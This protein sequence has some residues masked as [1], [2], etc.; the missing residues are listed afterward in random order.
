MDVVEA[1]KREIDPVEY[2]GRV[3]PLQKS[4]RSFKG[5]CPF[6]TE[7]T[8]SFYVFPDRGTWRCFGSCGEGGDIF[9]F[10]QKRE[11]SDFRGA[12]RTLAAEAGIELSAEDSRKR[13]HNERLAATM[14]A[15]V[16]Y[17][18]RCL[19][20]PGGEAAMAY[21]TEKRGLEQRTIETWRLGWAPDGWRGL[22]DFLRNRG[23]EDRDMIGAGLLIEGE[24]GRE[25]YDRFRGRVIIPIANERGE[26]IAM[27]G[28]GLQGE[29]PKYLNSPQTDLFDKGRTLFGLNIAA[30][31]I[32]E[33]STAIVVEGYMDVLGPWQAG[34]TNVVATMGTSLTENHAAL[35]KRFAKRIV[36]AMDPD[37]AGLAAAERAGDLFLGMQSA[38]GMGQSARTADAIT[39]A[40]QIDLRVAPLPQ[41]KDPDEVARETPDI[42]RAAIEDAPTFPEFLLR[43]LMDSETIES[44][45]QARATVDRL[46]PVLLAVSDP[47]ERAMYVQRVARHLGISEEA[48][49]ERLRAGLPARPGTPGRR[50]EQQVALLPEDVLLALLLKHPGLRQYFKNYPLTL[51]TGALER[52]LFSRWLGNGAFF[53]ED[54]DEDPVL[55][56]ARALEQK[57]LPPLTEQEA[58][59]AAQ[60]KVREIL[61]D[62]IVLHQAA[63]AEELAQAEKTLGANR[64]A[65]I[66][67]ATWRGGMPHEEERA[68]AESVIE[69]LQLG[70]SIHRREG[71]GAA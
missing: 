33:Q 8:P 56:R 16:D 7:K 21:L 47:V 4:G 13:T 3:T 62:R 11:N 42:W 27:G 65:E 49:I 9:T 46:R 23:Y 39:S 66:A 19:R 6:H 18:Q 38:E 34:F 59:R 36:L 17:Y 22:R 51:F 55:L 35:L 58:G 1:I 71:P 40:N 53:L 43:R 70:L 5:L 30:P 41:G 60:E 15:A 25:G 54:D 44:P 26:F 10:I 20:E 12:L 48:I 37:A 67:L 50:V 63:R 61:R 31:A 2:I 69:E 24:N 45:M 32:R 14:S 57:R 29:E 64:V 28:R 68:L 52:E